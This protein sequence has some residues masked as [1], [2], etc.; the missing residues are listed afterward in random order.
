MDRD[1][2]ALTGEPAIFPRDGSD[3]QTILKSADMAMYQ[4]KEEG[5][6][7]YRYYSEELNLEAS[8]RMQIEQDLRLALE[9]RDQLEL[10]YQP[11]I[12]TKT[13]KPSSAQALIRWK[14]PSP[15]GYL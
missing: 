11:K 2:L 14:H 4:A 15:N 3:Y 1:Q 13:G 9:N 5:K 10:Y 12:E 8:R 7:T 6:N